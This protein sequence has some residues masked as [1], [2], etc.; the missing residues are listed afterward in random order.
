MELSEVIITHRDSCKTYPLKRIGLSHLLD[1]TTD[2]PTIKELY[3][4]DK[5][6]KLQEPEFGCLLI[7]TH[8]NNYATDGYWQPHGITKDGKIFS[9]KRYDYGH[10]AVF[11]NDGFISDV[12]WEDGEG[13]II[14]LRKYS[15]LPKPDF[16]LKYIK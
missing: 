7:W 6:K 3:E 11:E 10:V 16:I 8:K 5:F 15:E 4:S 2:T 14:R 12:S 9:I 13:T 1:T